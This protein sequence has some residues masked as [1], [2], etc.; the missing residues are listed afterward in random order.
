MIHYL[1]AHSATLGKEISQFEFHGMLGGEHTQHT[2]EKTAQ[3]NANEFASMLNADAYLTA[4]DW[5]GKIST[6]KP[7]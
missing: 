7:T 2:S 6:V 4:T 3:A 1:Y 5:A